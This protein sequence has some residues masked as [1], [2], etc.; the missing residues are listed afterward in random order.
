[1]ARRAQSLSTR[2]GPTLHTSCAGS[3]GDVGPLK[4]K[5]FFI[6]LCSVTHSLVFG[7]MSFDKCFDGVGFLHLK[8]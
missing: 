3:S 6:C 8:V 7:F 2:P 1:M 5:F 4:K